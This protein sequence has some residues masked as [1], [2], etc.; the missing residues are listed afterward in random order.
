M[1]VH[2]YGISRFK[3]CLFAFQAL[4]ETRRARHE[5]F[6]PERLGRLAAL[7]AQAI[8]AAKKEG[9]I[10]AALA[11]ATSAPMHLSSG[12]EYGFVRR[13]R[14][15]LLFL[16][17][18]QAWGRKESLFLARESRG[19]LLPVL[20]YHRLMGA[21][22]LFA[23]EGEIVR[24][25]WEEDLLRAVPRRADFRMPLAVLSSGEATM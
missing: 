25:G 10:D 23:D 17:M 8:E 6:D 4:A 12:R 11:V 7:Q 3:A 21:H 9:L 24:G 16:S 14:L 1:P 20:F 19:D 22:G 18:P 2:S 5:R 13:R 15:D